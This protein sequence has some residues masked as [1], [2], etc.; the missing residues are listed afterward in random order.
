MGVPAHD[1]RDFSFAK[2]HQLD[3]KFVIQPPQDEV[4]SEGDKTRPGYYGGSGISAVEAFTDEGV[5]MNSEEYNGRTSAQ[6]RTD[7]SNVLAANDMGGETTQVCKDVRIHQFVIH[8]DMWTHLY[9]HG[10]RQSKNDIQICSFA[11]LAAGR[12]HTQI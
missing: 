9:T 7:I 10:Y 2:R 8:M 3:I 4:G 6:A 5:L 12:I 11:I 1:T